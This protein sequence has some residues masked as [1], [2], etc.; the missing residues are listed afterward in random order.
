MFEYQ[1]LIDNIREAIET[2]GY[3]QKAIAERIGK[4]PQEF[5]NMMNNRTNVTVIDV[6]N[7]SRALGVSPDTLYR[8]RS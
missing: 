6:Y 5:S 1:M 4:T 7:I 8:V 3:K 2:A